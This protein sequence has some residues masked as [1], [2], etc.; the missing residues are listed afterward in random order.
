M[1][2][3][4]YR[5]P[6]T[7][8]ALMV[9]IVEIAD[10]P[11]FTDAHAV[12]NTTNLALIEELGSRV[13]EALTEGEANRAVVRQFISREAPYYLDRRVAALFEGGSE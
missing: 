8:D 2:H 6:A 1:I 12:Y 7:G 3:K 10:G 11:E 9:E 4:T 5:T 13:F